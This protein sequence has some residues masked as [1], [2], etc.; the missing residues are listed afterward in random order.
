MS[1][2]STVVYVSQAQPQTDLALADGDAV[3]TDSGQAQGA[4][5]SAGQGAGEI[6]DP[7][8]LEGNEYKPLLDSEQ[9]KELGLKTEYDELGERWVGRSRLSTPAC[10]AAFLWP[11][12]RHM[13]TLLMSQCGRLTVRLHVYTCLHNYLCAGVYRY[14]FEALGE[15]LLPGETVEQRAE[16]VSE[17][18]KLMMCECV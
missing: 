6:A 3:P 16:R 2:L 11:H 7:D 15:E 13:G 1:C 12:I 4:S 5:D 17:A 10:T 14:E 8:G 9:M 18:V